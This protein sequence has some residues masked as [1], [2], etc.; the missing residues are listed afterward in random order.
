MIRDLWP[1]DVKSEKGI[2]PEAILKHQAETLQA[3]TKDLLR[4][5][6]TRTTTDDRVILGFEIVAPIADFRTRL[7]AVQHRVD[8]EYPVAILPPD[9]SLPQYL[10]ERFYQPSLSEITP[11]LTQAMASVL[12]SSGAVIENEW[13]AS[14]PTEFV[15]KIEALLSLPHVRAMVMSL[16]SRASRKQNGTD[17]KSNESPK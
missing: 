12:K 4:G 3:R 1:D 6:I 9:D 11:A 5:E 16:L 2:S 14:S 15:E 8:F 17:E 10:K 13:I 7:F